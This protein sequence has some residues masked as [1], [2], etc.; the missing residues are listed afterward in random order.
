MDNMNIT[1]AQYFTDELSGNNASV[2]ATIDGIEMSV[3]LD[4]NNRHYQA[5]LEWVAEGN[6]IQ[7]A[8]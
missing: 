1:A 5:I 7:E 8:D 2:T 3:P 6:T 4:P